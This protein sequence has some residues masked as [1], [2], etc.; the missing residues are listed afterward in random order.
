MVFQ[1]V[2]LSTAK[3]ELTKEELVAL[4]EQARPKNEELGVTGILLYHR[5][6]ILQA[7]E[8]DEDVVRSLYARIERDPRHHH[9][10]VLL[11]GH[12]PARDFAGWSMGFREIQDSEVREH[13]G[14][15]DLLNNPRMRT[16]NPTRIQKLLYTFAA[17]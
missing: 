12:Q 4:L 5:G 6:S 3:A 2:Y 17:G 14:F 15:N 10:I 11:Q 1:I 13:P 7:I 16:H 8:G 9:M